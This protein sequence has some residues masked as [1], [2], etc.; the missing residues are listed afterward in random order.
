MKPMM[1]SEHF[2]L[3]EFCDSEIADRH[4]IDNSLPLELLE[5]ARRTAAVLEK[6]RAHLGGAPIYISSGYRSKLVNDL[7]KSKDTSD[8]RK[9]LASDIKVF[10]FG[11]PIEVCRALLPVMDKLGIGQLIYEHTWTHIGLPMPEKLI[12]RVLTV[13]GSGYVPGIVEV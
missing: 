5:N 7:L 11:S 2:S 10:A 8:H 12:N 3:Q 1:L 6:V 9:A 13:T 4:K